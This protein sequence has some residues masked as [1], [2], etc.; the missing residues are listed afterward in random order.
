MINYMASKIF[1]TAVF[2]FC[3]GIVLSKATTVI[4]Y[5]QTHSLLICGECVNNT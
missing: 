2:F 3:N 1:A 4:T 5:S